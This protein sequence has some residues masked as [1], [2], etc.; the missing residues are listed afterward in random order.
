MSTLLHESLCEEARCIHRRAD[1]PAQQFA[2]SLHMRNV[3][4]FHTR[5]F[6]GADVLIGVAD[7]LAGPDRVR[8]V[9]L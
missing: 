7:D 2:A 4:T 9:Y 3:S 1:K 5:N 6:A 8:D